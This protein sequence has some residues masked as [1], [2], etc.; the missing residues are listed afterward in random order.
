[1]TLRAS[2]WVSTAL[3]FLLGTTF[4]DAEYKDQ[5]LQSEPQKL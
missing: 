1:M 5:Q 4:K 3:T 2:G